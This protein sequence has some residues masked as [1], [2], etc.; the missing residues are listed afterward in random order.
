MKC[1]LI[2]IYTI[3]YAVSTLCILHPCEHV[4]SINSAQLPYKNCNC[5]T[6][7]ILVNT[8]IKTRYYVKVVTQW[9][10]HAPCLITTFADTTRHYS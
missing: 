2:H 5:G 4:K 10:S 8:V 1:N 7:Y 9:N 6:H 3:V